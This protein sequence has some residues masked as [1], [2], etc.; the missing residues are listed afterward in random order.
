MAKIVIIDSGVNRRH[1]KLE[2]AHIEGIHLWKD[3]EGSIQVD[4]DV[5]DEYGHG[6]AVANIINRNSSHNEIVAVKIFD[7]DYQTDEEL[8]TA[9]LY[10]I[11]P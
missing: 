1:P 3:A 5:T 8:L 9:S 2:G 10:Y 4:D 6:T 11:Y 7:G